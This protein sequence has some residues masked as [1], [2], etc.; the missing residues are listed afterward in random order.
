V[1]GVRHACL[2]S[3]LIDD[4]YSVLFNSVED[5]GHAMWGEHIQISAPCEVNTFKWVRYSLCD[6]VCL[7]LISFYR[8]RK[9]DYNFPTWFSSLLYKLSSDVN[10]TGSCTIPDHQVHRHQPVTSSEPLLRYLLRV[11]WLIDTPFLPCLS[12]TWISCQSSRSTSAIL[13]TK[14]SYTTCTYVFRYSICSTA[15]TNNLGNY[16]GVITSQYMSKVRLGG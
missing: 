13:T 3:I 4:Q 1:A 14:Y 7:F 15:Y 8:L 5:G 2:S 10:F 16:K 6:F 12:I 11:C 9:C